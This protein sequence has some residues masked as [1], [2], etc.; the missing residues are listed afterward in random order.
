VEDRFI[1]EYSDEMDDTARAMVRDFSEEYASKMHD[2]R[3]RLDTNRAE[4]RHRERKRGT[5][6]EE[7]DFVDMGDGDEWQAAQRRRGQRTASATGGQSAMGASAA[8]TSPRRA[9]TP[10]VGGASGSLSGAVAAGLQ[11]AGDAAGQPNGRGDG[12]TVA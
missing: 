3:E 10:A 4:K 7:N 9:G 6:A 8:P 11:K 2:L 1:K 5:A 12:S